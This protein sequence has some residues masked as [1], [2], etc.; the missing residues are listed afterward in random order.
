MVFNP[1]SIIGAGAK[2]ITGVS[3]NVSVEQT[4]R[5]FKDLSPKI[6]R[7]GMVFNQA[8]SGHLVLRAALVARKQGVQLVTRKIRYPREAIKALNSL[9]DKIDALWILPDETI[10]V[11]KVVQYMLLFSSRNKVPVLGLSEKQT[12]MGALLSLS[13][14]SSR[15]MGRQAGE[16]ANSILSG[17]KP[18]T[19]P[20][21]TPRQVKLTVNLRAAQKLGVEIPNRVLERADNAIKAPVYKDGDW[22]VF[23]VKGE[24]RP[25]EEY[26][27]TYKNGKFESD[28]PEFLTGS[29]DS[30]SFVF[31]PLVSVHLNDPERRWLDFPLVAGKKWDFGSFHWP[32]DTVRTNRW[33]DAEAEIIGPAPQPVE[34][35]AGK[36]KVIEIRQVFERQWYF[37][38][39]R[40]VPSVPNFT[41]DLV[42]FYSPR[43]KSVVKQTTHLVSNHMDEA[44]YEMELI[45]YGHEAPAVGV[46]VVKA[47]K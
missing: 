40:G 23:R 6:R 34:T 13:Y 16:M 12:R 25:S 36:F 26:R 47:P 33:N 32:E 20:Y 9:Q 10:L 19:I 35:P 22:W 41:I 31:G 28:D 11:I 27:V 38:A 39:P 46:P 29:D 30:Y 17:T 44:E 4:I 3:M 1:I 5:L 15:D 21:T 24:G 18:V 45:S 2:N 37:L 43:T 8:R 14:G 42:Y 7:V